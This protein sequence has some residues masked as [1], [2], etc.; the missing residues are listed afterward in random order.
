MHTF[1]S[2]RHYTSSVRAPKHDE[3]TEDDR[4]N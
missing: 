1:V 2:M 3:V 4:Y